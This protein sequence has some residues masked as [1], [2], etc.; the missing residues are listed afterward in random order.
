MDRKDFFDAM[1]DRW[2]A[3]H[4]AEAHAAGVLHGLA[5]VGPL[6]GKAVADVGC[7]TGVLAPHLLSRLGAGSLLGIDFAPEMIRRA[8]E[9]HPDPRARWQACDVLETGLACGSVDVV[10][11]FNTLPHFADLPRVVREFAR[12]LRDG[13]RVLVWHDAGREKIAA[14]HGHVG[15]PIGADC[16]PPARDLGAL[17]ERCGLE[18]TVAEETPTSYAVLAQRPAARG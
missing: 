4:P 10:L 6:D 1:A 13:G 16:L 18:V 17:F 11:C 8:R 3:L 5:L 15:G 2:D 14:I 7:G 9:R 12:W